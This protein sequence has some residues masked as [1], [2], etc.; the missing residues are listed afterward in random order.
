MTKLDGSR[1][2]MVDEDYYWR[3]I[4]TAPLGAKLQILTCGGVAIHGKLNRRDKEEGYY[5]GWTPLP[6]IPK[7]MK[8]KL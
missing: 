6:K 4:S 1:Q 7:E 5:L 2:A 8:E 3:D